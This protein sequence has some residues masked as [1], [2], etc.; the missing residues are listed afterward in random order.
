MSDSVPRSTWARLGEVCVALFAYVILVWVLLYPLFADP[1]RQVYDPSSRPDGW[2]TAPVAQWAMWAMA[3]DWHALTSDA[4]RLF[5]AN[6]FHPTP[7]ALATSQPLLGQLALFAPV[8]ALTGNMVLGYQINLM[9]AL[10]LCGAAMYALLR[11]WGAGR[12]AAFFAGFVYAL[13]PVRLASLTHVQMLTAQYLPLVVIA[14]DKTL[15]TGRLRHALA[16]TALL[17]L[18]VLCSEEL[19]YLT[20]VASLGYGA[21]VLWQRRGVTMRGAALAVVAVMIGAAVAYA[22]R[23]P[24]LQL[25]EAGWIGATDWLSWARLDSAGWLRNYLVPAVAAQRW[26]WLL[27]GPSVY[28]GLVPLALAVLAWRG[29]DAAPAGVPAWRRSAAAGT[30]AVSYLMALGPEIVVAG[31]ELPAPQSLARVLMPD[32]STVVTPARFALTLMLGLAGLAGLGLHAAL[33]RL[34]PARRRG[35]A[36]WWVTGL[37]VVLTGVEFGLPFA[38]YPTRLV[39]AG[40][41]ARPVH[42]ALARRPAGAVLEIPAVTCDLFNGDLESFYTASSAAHWRPLLNGYGSRP[43]LFHSSVVALAE[44]LPDPRAAELLARM[45]GLRHVVV[46]LARLPHAD[47]MRW[48]APPGLELVGFFG[49][50]LLFEVVGASAADLLPRLDQSP[51]S[52][53]TLLGNALAPLPPAGRRARLTAAGHWPEAVSA[54]FDFKVLVQVTNRSGHTWP[55]LAWGDAA[56]TRVTLAYRWE[57]AGGKIVAGNSVAAPLPYD[58]APGET[59]TASLC[60]AAPANAGPARLVIGL[61]QGGEWFADT[62]PATA[63]DVVELA[64]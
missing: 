31:I 19:A 23:V 64:F 52:A 41:L 11:H 46:H 14:A 51:G 58:L 20:L 45:T 26:T 1:A 60:V 13:C 40:E 54:G 48:S 32:F 50:D 33:E 29:G 62:T 8:H 39:E 59:V 9:L 28:V 47:R 53:S 61:A 2:L 44:T 30:I 63:M 12:A 21:G 5:D 7:S 17:L 37:L 25:A 56:R 27:S 4:A 3:W 57:D 49:S 16:L 18:Q 10:A 38:R 55:A 43:P 36:A 35:P 15:S 24:R 42:R 34:A 22:L 6:V